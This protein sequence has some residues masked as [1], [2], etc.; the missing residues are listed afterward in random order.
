MVGVLGGGVPSGRKAELLKVV[1]NACFRCQPAQDLVRE[2]VGL[3]LV[4]N[5][6]GVD[7]ANPLLRWGR[8]ARGAEGGRASNSNGSTTVSL[9]VSVCRHALSCMP[10]A[11][12]RSRGN[13]KVSIGG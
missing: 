5:H 2:E 9:E 4:L 13:E 1:G 8:W 12:L 7:E 10:L 11:L 6:C 3:P